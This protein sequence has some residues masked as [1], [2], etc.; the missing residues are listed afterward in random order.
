MTRTEAPPAD[1]L[2]PPW[3]TRGAAPVPTGRVLRAATVRTVSAV[4]VELEQAR[5]TRV[6][7]DELTRQLAFAHAQGRAAG[8]ADTL[9]QGQQAVLSAAEML[10][11][12]CATVE[13]QQDREVRATATAVVELALLV[14]QWMLR[15]ELSD[16][17]AALLNRLEEGLLAL[18][19]SPTTRLSV[20][21]V[22]HALVAEWA[23]SR[24]RVGTQVVADSRLAPGDAVV[25]TDA[26]HAELTVAA[27]LAAAAEALGLTTAVDGPGSGA[28]L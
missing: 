22:D 2:P 11:T 23:A 4:E 7:D 16:D 25:V 1:L 24:G 15:R 13:A 21:H 27:A 8:V 28:V 12:L 10:Q 6:L 20:S 3:A 18:L 17:G 9:A 5:R 19:P 14:S 26:G